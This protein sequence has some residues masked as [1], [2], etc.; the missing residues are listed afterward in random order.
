M[1]AEKILTAALLTL[2]SVC[3]F[4]APEAEKKEV[5]ILEGPFSIITPAKPPQKL[6]GKVWVKGWG[7]AASAGIEEGKI[8]L[9]V[10]VIYGFHLAHV[11]TAPRKLVLTVKASAI[12]EAKK[13]F[14]NGYFSTCVR[15]PGNKKPFAH[16]NK[17]TFGPFT[18]TSEAKEFKIEYDQKP[19]E[20]GYIYLGGANLM[21]HSIRLVA[22]PGEAAK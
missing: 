2:L 3:S 21:I 16:E 1:K 13:S 18:L 7:L 11:T 22:I 17:T 14:L 5:V 12:P 15:E 6:E 9:K 10:G 8:K 20:Q 19:Y 4:A